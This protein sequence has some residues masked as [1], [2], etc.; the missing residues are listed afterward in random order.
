MADKTVKCPECGVSIPLEPLES[1]AAIQVARH[2]CR[3]DGAWREVI[4]VMPEADSIKRAEPE[5][6]AKSKGE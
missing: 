4:R 6:P 5:K 1:N 3:A 2:N